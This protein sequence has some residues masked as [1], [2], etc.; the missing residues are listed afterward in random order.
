VLTVVALTGAANG[1]D[2]AKTL[3]Q[4]AKLS[5]HVLA[6][7][8]GVNARGDVGDVPAGAKAWMINA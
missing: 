5:R 3:T 6:S 8:D 4:F 2:D 7:A 1:L